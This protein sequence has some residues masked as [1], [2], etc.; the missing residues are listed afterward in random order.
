[1][2]KKEKLKNKGNGTARVHNEENREKA[3]RMVR[4][5]NKNASIRGRRIQEI[6]TKRKRRRGKGTW[7]QKVGKLGKA[8]GKTVEEMRNLARY[9]RR[10]KKW[11]NEN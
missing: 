7:L 2:E 10:Q 6:G 9:I 8:R 4:T 5:Y 11:R 3:T 1:M